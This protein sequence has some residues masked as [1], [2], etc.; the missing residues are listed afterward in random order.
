MYR[1]MINGKV[2]VVSGQSIIRACR[3][4]GVKG[5]SSVTGILGFGYSHKVITITES[6]YVYTYM[7]FN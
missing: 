3:Q 2:S 1:W 4:S 6:L 5:F 7:Y